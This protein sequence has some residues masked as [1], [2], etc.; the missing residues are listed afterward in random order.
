MKKIKLTL[1][2][3]TVSRLQDDQQEKVFGGAQPTTLRTTC[4]EETDYPI[5]GWSGCLGDTS[6]DSMGYTYQDTY[7]TEIT[8]KCQNVNL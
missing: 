4:I 7:M 6:Y 2:K 1:N 8:D 3:T 5:C